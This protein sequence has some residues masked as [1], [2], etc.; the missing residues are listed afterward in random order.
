MMPDLEFNLIPPS[1]YP[2]EIELSLNTTVKIDFDVSVE[3]GKGG[4]LPDY[5]GEYTVKPKL[6]EQVLPTNGKSMNDDVTVE[7]VPVSRVTNP[8][9]GTTVVIC[10]N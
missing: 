4:K 3:I 9:Q 8:S 5:E 1:N 2:A 7:E 6:V 10:A